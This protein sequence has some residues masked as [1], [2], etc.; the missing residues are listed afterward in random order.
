MHAHISEES[1]SQFTDRQQSTQV[2]D[3]LCGI[4]KVSQ[5]GWSLNQSG[6]P[7]YCHWETL[8][9]RQ[10]HGTYLQTTRLSG[11]S[12]QGLPESTEERNRLPENSSPALDVTYPEGVGWLVL[13]ETIPL[14][15]VFIFPDRSSVI[16][17]N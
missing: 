10:V 12:L 3:S 4:S 11:Q 2:L 6:P 14:L 13:F 15:G 1:A 9:Y 5:G 16:L 8:N 7:S 17:K